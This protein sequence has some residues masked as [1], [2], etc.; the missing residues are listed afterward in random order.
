M[1]LIPPRNPIWGRGCEKKTPNSRRPHIGAG[2]ILKTDEQVSVFQTSRLRQLQG[3]DD[4]GGADMN[5]LASAPSTVSISGLSCLPQ[6]NTAYSLQSHLLNG[7]PH[8]RTEGALS[9]LTGHVYLYWSAHPDEGTRSWKID[10]DEDDANFYAFIYSDAETPPLGARTWQEG[11]GSWTAAMLTLSAQLSLSN[12]VALARS[13]LAHPTCADVDQNRC[14]AR[15]A[16]LWVAADSAAAQCSPKAAMAAYESTI[17]TGVRAACTATTQA[18]VAT[19]P[20]RLAVNGLRCHPLANAVYVLQQSPLNGRPHYATADSSWHLYWNPKLDYVSG[21]TAWV[22]DEATGGDAEA[23][24]TTLVESPVGSSVWNEYCDHAWGNAR[25]QLEPSSSRTGWCMDAL[26][27][28]APGLT[29]TCCGLSDGETCGR[30][31]N[32]PKKCSVDCAHMWQPYAA[33]C[34]IKS[35][36]GSPALMSFF[37]GQCGAVVPTIAVLQE[38]ATIQFRLTHDF[39]FEGISGLRYQVDVRVGD[40]SGR[41]GPCTI[42]AADDPLIG[43]APDQCDGWIASGVY[44]CSE[45][46]CSE[47]SPRN[48]YCDKSCGFVCQENGSTDTNLFVLPPGVSGKVTAN[49]AVV[50]EL[51]T[52]ADKG[53]GFS[54]T[55]T[56]QYSARVYSNRGSGPVSVTVVAVGTALERSPHMRLDGAPHSLTTTCHFEHC[57]FDYDGERMVDADGAGFDLV[58]PDAQ[59][60]YGYA[61]KVELPNGQTAAQVAVTV[62]QAGAQAGSAG[63]SPVVAGPMGAWSS[64]PAGHKTLAEFVPD[65][66]LR[67]SFGVHPGERFGSVQEGTWVAPSSGPALVR[68]VLNCD[69]VFMADVMADGCSVHGNTFDCGEDI[70]NNGACTS[71]LMLT[72]TPN[73]HFGQSS[74]D[75]SLSD[76]PHEVVTGSVEH[77][78][79]IV[80]SR[81]T[82]EARALAIWQRSPEHISENAPTME[83]MLQSGTEQ[84]ALLTSMFTTTQQPHVVYPLSFAV[85][86]KGDRRR[87]QLQGDELTITIETHAPSQAEAAAAVQRLATDH[88]AVVTGE[89]EDDNSRRRR[90][91]KGGDHLYHGDIHA[92]CGLG[93][94]EEGCTAAGQTKLRTVMRLQ[95]R[96]VESAA[97]DKLESTPIEK[98]TLATPP[99]LDE[100]LVSGT[101]ANALLA[102][103]FVQEQQ[104]HLAVP[105]AFS[106]GMQCAKRRL[107]TGGDL[108]HVTVD[109]HAAT[110]TEANRALERLAIQNGGT[111]CD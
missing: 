5:V 8:Y 44:S 52:S 11:C 45:D 88:G 81:E 105:A 89:E 29:D 6:G 102:S 58:L 109:T 3:G 53:V 41:S 62:Y 38:T 67:S 14:S 35:D 100:M 19:A 15:C 42:N 40:G 33:A 96:V 93:S 80:I 92:V 57:T 7:R 71:E 55:S 4:S 48:N 54:A 9:Y 60:G 23:Y 91:Q 98:R 66:T 84:H 24:L 74:D 70:D 63:F 106:P 82:L 68:V 2:H 79:S 26:A 28:L 56:G 21:S 59:A 110:P 39:L 37:R 31:G 76:G 103:V 47:C 83:N 86:D 72:V 34:P 18:A 87:M 108:L 107:Q 69:V 12:C 94:T 32:L 10:N 49:Q 22:V 13:T 95:R 46:F 50:T 85:S 90:L 27:Q 77:T 111:V 1:C 61:V 104:P 75:D 16:E 17:P 51:T 78:G 64:T 101:P 97:H 73:A 36:T 25:L 99:S 30:D 20:T 65:S 43:G